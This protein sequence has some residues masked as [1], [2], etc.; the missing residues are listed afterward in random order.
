MKQWRKN[1]NVK[2]IESGE[3]E[4]IEYIGIIGYIDNQLNQV[5]LLCSYI[6][7]WIPIEDILQITIE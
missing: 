5:K 3:F 7:V 6:I 1:L 2:V 4:N